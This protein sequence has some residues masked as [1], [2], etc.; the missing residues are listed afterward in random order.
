M[1]QENLGKCAHRGKPSIGATGRHVTQ[2]ARCSLGV[3]G[4][5]FKL[6]DI[7]WLVFGF[8]VTALNFGN[9][10]EHR[11]VALAGFVATLASGLTL[12]ALVFHER[13]SRRRMAKPRIAE[14]PRDL[15]HAADGQRFD[16]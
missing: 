2:H 1:S 5:T 9:A 10:F 7:M 3:A 11:G 12:G 8:S 4:M 15:S 14:P 13:R 6:K 16:R